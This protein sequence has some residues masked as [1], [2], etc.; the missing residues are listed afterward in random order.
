MLRV[1]HAIGTTSWVV[2]LS[3]VTFVD[4]QQTPPSHSRQ[5][6]VDKV[7]QLLAGRN[8]KVRF[9]RLPPPFAHLPLPP[10]T[11]VVLSV[12]EPPGFTEVYLEL[13][14]PTQD[15]HAMNTFL[16]VFGNGGWY[17]GDSS[18]GEARVYRRNATRGWDS[19]R[20]DPVSLVLT[21]LG[22]RLPTPEVGSGYLCHIREAGAGVRLQY[23]TF[24]RY[25][26]APAD[27]RSYEDADAY[28]TF[29]HLGL[30]GAHISG[31]LNACVV[32]SNALTKT[33]GN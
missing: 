12:G 1:V 29:V 26:D 28:A 2:L 11:H 21:Q 23:L 27:L 31:S 22:Q 19:Y 3:I 17:V 4:A 14:N 24:D 20:L 10:G 32:L 16:N 33:L 9:G 6:E 18:H 8:G 7:V 5:A 13:P 15:N 30:P 25:L